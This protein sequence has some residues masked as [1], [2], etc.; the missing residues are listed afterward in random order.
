MSRDLQQ[1]CRCCLRSEL[2]KTPAR[3]KLEIGVQGS[4]KSHKEKLNQDSPGI[5]KGLTEN[6]EGEM[7][8]TDG[9]FREFMLEEGDHIWIKVM[10]PIQ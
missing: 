8:R 6:A 2:R 10:C 5:F 4:R 9:V 1:L 3:S 7:E